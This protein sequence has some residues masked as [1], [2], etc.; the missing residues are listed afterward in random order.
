M[1]EKIK[2]LQ[3][4]YDDFEAAA[5]PYK[6]EAACAKGCAFCCTDAG[7]IHI[8]TLEGRVIQDCIQRLPRNRQVA[9]K[10]ALAADMK[11]RERNQ[12][13][14]CPLLMKN[15][16]CMIYDQRPFACRRIYSLKTCSQSQHPVLN[17]KVMDLGDAAIKALQK[18]DGNGYSGHLSYILFM[19]E[20]PAFLATYLSGEYRPEA[21]MQFGKSHGIVINRMAR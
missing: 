8:T 7:S 5:A 18:L 15:R 17:K 21:V 12:P 10:K 1:E 11:R 14:A 2:Q 16:A 13:S 20:T 3:S 9:V 4:I 6:A 19:L